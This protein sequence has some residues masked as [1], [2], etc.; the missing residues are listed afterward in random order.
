[1][2]HRW[3]MLWSNPT[4]LSIFLLAWAG[5]AAVPAATLLRAAVLVASGLVSD[6]VK[7][8]ALRNSLGHWVEVDHAANTLVLAFGL[9]VIAPL[10][11]FFVF[12]ADA[13]TP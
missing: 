12:F 3:S 6:R 11:T 4:R 13:V 8:P 5:L 1:M 7:D 9:C 10:V 2:S